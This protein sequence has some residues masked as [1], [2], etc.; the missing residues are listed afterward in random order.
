MLTAARDHPLDVAR[1]PA[2][3]FVSRLSLTEFRCYARARLE[4][5]TSPVVLTG[6]NGAGKTAILEALSLLAPGRGMRRAPLR[7]LDRRAPGGADSACWSVAAQVT[8]SRG[9]VALGTGRDPDGEEKRVVRVDGAPARSQK[10]LADHVAIA[11]TSPEHDRLFLDGPSGR[12]RFLDRL[13]FGFAPEHAGE[14]AA[15]EHCLRERARLIAD[16]RDDDRWLAALEDGMA[17]HGIAVAAMRAAIVRQLDAAACE[18]IGPFPTARLALDARTGRHRCRCP[19]AP[20]RACDA[21]W[22]DS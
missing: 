18:A 15:Y 3:E 7:E 13:V 5:D 19:P 1:T 4:V 20:A 11:W 14:L 17:R 2:V 22:L 10:A 6:P 16:G 8:G 21:T 12:R 9:S